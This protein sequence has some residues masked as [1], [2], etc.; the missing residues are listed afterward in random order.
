M[1]QRRHGCALRHRL[2]RHLF[3]TRCCASRIA[4][5]LA[6]LLAYRAGVAPEPSDQQ[7]ADGHEHGH[8]G[9]VCVVHTARYWGANICLMLVR[10]VLV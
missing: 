7:S 8:A 4:G 10:C 2:L 1:Q 5:S 6:Q 3:V 9:F